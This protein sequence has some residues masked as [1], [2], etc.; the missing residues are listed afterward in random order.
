MKPTPA[1]VNHRKARKRPRA[2]RTLP[3]D[4]VR[5]FYGVAELA[6]YLRL[7]PETTARLLKA[8]SVDFTRIGSRRFILADE[9]ALKLPRVWASLVRVRNANIAREYTNGLDG[10]LEA[11]LD[12]LPAP[13]LD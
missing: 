12:D 5:P 6:R 8:A 11:A 3:L 10:D 2:S 1:E 7:P 13:D 4:E 9:L